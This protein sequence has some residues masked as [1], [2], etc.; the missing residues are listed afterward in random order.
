MP[1][2]NEYRDRGS[3][4]RSEL[5]QPIAPAVRPSRRPCNLRAAALAQAP[6]P[7]D[8]G[9]LL[10]AAL[11]K[12]GAA[13]QKAWRSLASSESTNPSSGAAVPSP[14]DLAERSGRARRY[15]ADMGEIPAPRAPPTSL[16]WPA[17][18]ERQ[19]FLGREASLGGPA[20]R[21]IPSLQRLPRSSGKSSSGSLP[22]P[23]AALPPPRQTRHTTPSCWAPASRSA[24]SRDCSLPTARR[25]ATRHAAARARQPSPTRPPAQLRPARRHRPPPPD[26]R[27]C[28]LTATTTTEASRRRSTST[29]CASAAPAGPSRPPLLAAAAPA[30]ACGGGSCGAASYGCHTSVTG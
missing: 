15:T 30:A 26:H 5:I 1:A 19:L 25:R 12:L 28:T 9:R 4:G 22:W 29:R 20:A 16:H 8:I 10:L 21:A 2:V 6:W 23:P 14:L 11:L 13:S 3:G 18:R 17:P 24:L 7:P 27:Y